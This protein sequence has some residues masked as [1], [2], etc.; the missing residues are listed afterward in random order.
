MDYVHAHNPR[1]D[2]GPEGV[3]ALDQARE[4]YDLIKVIKLITFQFESRKDL[5][6]ALTRC[7]KR[8]MDCKQGPDISLIKHEQNFLMLVSTYKVCGGSLGLPVIIR[9][10][11]TK[12]G[13]TMK[14][15][16]TAE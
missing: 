3:V 4:L 13:Y 8:I 2:Q 1:Q 7:L 14:V 12:A 9:R 15:P 6:T 16:S 5:T 11:F 10:D